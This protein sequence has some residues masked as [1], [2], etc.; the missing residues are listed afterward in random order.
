[1]SRELTHSIVSS[2]MSK[3]DNV[4]WRDVGHCFISFSSGLCSILPGLPSCRESRVMGSPYQ[5]I[6]D[7]SVS[8]GV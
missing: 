6:T 4:L 7:R 2:V 1:M 5:C 3:D 8:S